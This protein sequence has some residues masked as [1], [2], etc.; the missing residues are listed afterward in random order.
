MLRGAT[1]ARLSLRIPSASKDQE[2]AASNSSGL[3][4]GP[5][6]GRLNSPKPMPTQAIALREPQLLGHQRQTGNEQNQRAS[7][8]GRERGL[9]HSVSFDAIAGS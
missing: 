1:D 5:G 8:R 9:G 2:V 7:R 3:G 6:T 4:S